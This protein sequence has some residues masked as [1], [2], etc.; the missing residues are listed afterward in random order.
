MSDASMAAIARDLA[1]ALNKWARERGDAEKKAVA[2]AQADL[3]A[4]YR[5]ELDESPPT[6]E[7]AHE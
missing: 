3:C 4:A 1:K 2:Q 5:A 6:S 7:G